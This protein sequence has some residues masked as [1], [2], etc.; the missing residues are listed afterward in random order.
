MKAKCLNQS[1]T[2]LLQKMFNH[3]TA[4]QTLDYIGITS[5]EIDEA[6]RNL[7]LG[8]LTCN[9]LIDSKLGETESLLA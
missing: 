1:E 6:Y 2:L 3:S 7:N 5:D 4:S 9:Y 8:S